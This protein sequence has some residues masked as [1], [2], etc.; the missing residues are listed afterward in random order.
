MKKLKVKNGL[1]RGAMFLACGLAAT[2]CVDDSWDLDGEMDMTMQLGAEGLALK[3]GN[4]ENI[5][6]RDILTIDEGD[7]LDTTRA[8]LYYL[9][10]D[11]TT[12]VDFTVETL[13]TTIDPATLTPTV[14]LVN[15]EK[16]LIQQ[17]ITGVD[18][19]TIPAGE[20]YSESTHATNEFKVNVSGINADEIKALKR[21]VPEG[22]EFRLIME[23]EQSP[24]LNFVISEMRDVE[25]HL[26]S[27]AISNNDAPNGVY[28]ISDMQPGSDRIDLGTIDLEYVDF[29][30]EGVAITPEGSFNATDEI[31]MTGYFAFTAAS[32][33]DMRNDDY[34]NV[35]LTIEVDGST[36]GELTLAEVE[37]KFTPA[38][39][40][41]VDPIRIGDDLPDFLDDDRVRI[42]VNN[43]TVRFDV[44]MQQ[45]PVD[46][47]FS[48]T[49]NGI[50]AGTQ[51]TSVN[52]P[53]QGMQE[54]AGEQRNTI[55]FYQGNEPF[56]ITEKPADAVLSQVDNLSSLVEQ[57]PD[58][59]QID[60][61]NANNRKIEVKDE[62]YT[63]E[64][65]RSYRAGADYKVL[66]PLTFDAGLNI[67][68]KDSVDDMN[69]D[70]QDY[71]ADGFTVTATATNTIPLQ[72]LVTAKAY[73][74]EGR[75]I[76]G[77]DVSQ[78]TIAPAAGGQAT[79]SEIELK[80]RL[81]NRS[82]LKRLEEIK[83]EV[84]ASA[85]NSDALNSAQYLR[86]D[87]M[88]LRLDGPITGDFN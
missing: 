45:I 16:A 19:I 50:T 10:E 36:T 43:P 22:G 39:E 53:A 85:D 24:G 18:H 28:H 15:F 29:G 49:A 77:F 66:V 48:A 59:I 72:L 37:G 82:D 70:L 6:L 78:A 14:E 62:F 61:G 20:T 7:N 47:N 44:D 88:R 55:Y 80:V 9:V 74:T 5:Y 27:F 76:P 35:R 51:T 11:G 65:G 86:L 41:T 2:S 63:I 17:G 87:N 84:T 40:P 71:E 54:L 4:S 21:I 58:E 67:V 23:V 57:I 81:Q 83:F 42:T 64:L 38:I 33:F 26:P 8:G 52:L 75:E 32:S 68:Y 13:T 31:S 12:D 25:L 79:T 1:L 30:D 3:L 46:L 73:D 69:S 34:A 60:L 56:D